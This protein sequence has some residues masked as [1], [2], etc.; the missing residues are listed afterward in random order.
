MSKKFLGG[1]LSMSVA[2]SA[3]V[4]EAA[5]TYNVDFNRNAA[6]AL[7]Y[8]GTAIAPDSGT[9]WNG[10]SGTGANGSFML[11]AA[12][13]LLDSLGNVGT[14]DLT[15]TTIYGSFSASTG[16]AGTPVPHDLMYDYI[17]LRGGNNPGNAGGVTFTVSDLPNGQYKLWI[18]SA[19]DATG[20]DG[21]LD[22]ALANQVTGGA[23][24]AMTSGLSR[25]I[26]DAGNP[27]VNYVVLDAQTVGGSLSFQ[28]NLVGDETST[29]NF[30]A[31]NGFQIQQVV[32][33]PS[34][35][36]LFVVAIV[37]MAAGRRHWR[38]C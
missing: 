31:L 13:D 22:I 33:E 8:S 25:D 23:S 26:N 30:S 10:I 37:G 12:N 4:V 5:L 14:A 20:Q 2:L 18:Y 21:Q 11:N 24:S 38:V 7:T 35:A 28:W 1:L 32:P 27:G 16:S 9:T 3:S 34:A 17:T 6:G 15:A 36:I 29:G 19:G